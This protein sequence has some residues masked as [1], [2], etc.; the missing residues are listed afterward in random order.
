MLEALACGVPVIVPGGS[1]QAEVAGE[2]G[3][4]VNAEDA[5]SVAAGLAKG[6]APVDAVGQAKEFVTEAIR[7]SF[8][9]GRG[10][11]PLNHF[12]KLWK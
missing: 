1:A 9:I 4:E 7:L 5:D 11:G 12:Y 3:I 10:H 6:L 8:P 2:P